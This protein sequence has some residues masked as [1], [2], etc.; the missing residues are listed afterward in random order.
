M[1]VALLCLYCLSAAC[2]GSGDSELVGDD[3]NDVPSGIIDQ[4]FDDSSSQDA[5]ELEGFVEAHNVERA[6]VDAT[7][8][9]AP[10]TWS[11]VLA[12]YAQ[13]WVDELV[14]RGCVIGHR[15]DEGEF[16]RIYGESTVWYSVSL[17]KE[18]ADAVAF[19]AGEKQYY[20]A[21][22]HTCESGKICGHYTQMVWRDTQQ[23]GCATAR[24][25]PAGEDERQIW[26]CNY[27][28]RGNTGAVPF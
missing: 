16:K 27:D 21:E 23:L 10:L 6:A 25:T 1:R 13:E 9:L 5:P 8:P 22:N 20:D 2:S 12:N 17:G 7:P 19:W 3:I 4:P 24:C 18:K 15:P 26:V 28:P 14:R 11:T